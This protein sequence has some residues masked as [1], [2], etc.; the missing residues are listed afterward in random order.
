MTP[1]G[2]TLERCYVGMVALAGTLVLVHAIATVLTRQI[3]YAWL[4]F[5]LLACAGSSLAI[6][7]PAIR[8]TLFISEIFVFAQ[9]VLF[10]YAPAAVT[11]A[12]GNLV[13]SLRRRESS[14]L[15]ECFNIAEPAF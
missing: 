14:P 15:R 3:G 7:V 9:I 6:K 11:V 4:A 10:G 8:A 12:L 2:S 13:M 5:A 1:K